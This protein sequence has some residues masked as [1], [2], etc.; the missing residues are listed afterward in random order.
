VETA[1]Q[2][3][4]V[5]VFGKRI[6]AGYLAIQ[7]V[8]GVVWWITLAVSPWVRGRFELMPSQHAVVDAFVLADLA[9]VVVGSAV[10]AWAIERE[11]DWAVP[12]VWFTTGGIVYPTL[13]LVAWVSLV[14]TGSGLLAA[15]VAVSTLTTWVAFQVTLAT[16]RARRGVSS[17]LRREAGH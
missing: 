6:Y 2:S 13:F 4:E 14:G 3:D 1:E 16:R 11:S 5:V 12:A 7:A 8:L 10:G 15:M 17:G 9:V